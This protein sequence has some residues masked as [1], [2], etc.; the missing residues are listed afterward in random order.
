MHI[1]AIV[2]QSTIRASG[3]SIVERGRLLALDDPAILELASQ[4]CD[5]DRI[6]AETR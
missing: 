3:R 2:F 4:H 6:L 5:P 1:D